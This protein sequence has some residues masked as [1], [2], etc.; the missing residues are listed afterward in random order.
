MKTSMAASA[1]FV[2]SLI[3]PHTSPYLLTI[4]DSFRGVKPGVQHISA[5]GCAVVA[6]CKSPQPELNTEHIASAEQRQT[7]VCL[8]T[9]T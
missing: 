3:S 5:Q 8:Q 9:V 4:S 6:A 2:L 7:Q 1:Y